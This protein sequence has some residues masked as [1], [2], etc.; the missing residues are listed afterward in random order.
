ML[1]LENV[2][3]VFK[4]KETAGIVTVWGKEYYKYKDDSNYAHVGS[5]DPLSWIKHHWRKCEDDTGT[6]YIF[7]ANKGHIVAIPKDSYDEYS[8]DPSFTEIDVIDDY[9]DWIEKN[10]NKSGGINEA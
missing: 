1:E 8:G 9:L 6:I 3:Y 10:Y 7:R 4:H 5:L 2:V